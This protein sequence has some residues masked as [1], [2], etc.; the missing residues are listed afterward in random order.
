MNY[1]QRTKRTKKQIGR[2]SKNVK[3]LM[4]P[5]KKVRGK[6]NKRNFAVKVHSVSE[7]D[8]VLSTSFATYKIP[9]SS[10]PIVFMKAKQHELQNVLICRAQ[11]FR[12]EC[13]YVFELYW[14]D[15]DVL[16]DIPNLKRFVIND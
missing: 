9:R 12:Y 1:R 6:V 13:G 14:Y 2:K 4:L 16:V 15:L 8:V 10:S 11:T 3:R 5:K 7:T